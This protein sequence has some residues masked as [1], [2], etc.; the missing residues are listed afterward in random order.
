MLKSATGVMKTFRRFL[1]D[2]RGATS[3]IVIVGVVTT[4]G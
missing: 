3:I 2:G 4:L 1:Y